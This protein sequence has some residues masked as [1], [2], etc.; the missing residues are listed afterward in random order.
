MRI[1]LFKDIYIGN[2][3]RIEKDPTGESCRVFSY[4][5]SYDDR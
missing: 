2:L 3:Y 4:V 5:S 1:D